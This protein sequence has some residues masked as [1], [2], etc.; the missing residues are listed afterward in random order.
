MLSKLYTSDK[1]ANNADAILN[2]ATTG[3][4]F[5]LQHART[6]D[7][8]R[9]YFSLTEDGR[10]LGIQR[11][12]FSECFFV[13]AMYEYGKATGDIKYT[14]AG[15]DMF[16]YVL[17]YH[18]KPELLGRPQLSGDAKLLPLNMPMIILNVIDEIGM[19]EKYQDRVNR[20]IHEILLHVQP[21]M[22]VVVENV[23]P[24]GTVLMARSDGRLCNPGHAIECAW[25]LLHHIRMVGCTGEFKHR[26][27]ELNNVAINMLDWS[28]DKGWD[29]QHDGILYFTDLA[30]YDASPLE[31]GMKLWWPHCETLIAMLMAFEHTSKPQYLSKFIQTIDY[32]KKTF[33]ATPSGGWYGYFDQ[34]GSRTHNYIGAAY[35]GFFHVPRALFVC[36]TILERLLHQS[37]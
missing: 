21:D 36:G 33:S 19:H 22:Q 15:L 35:K 6:E 3:A 32:I 26:E 10:P 27:Q 30:G 14:Q 4:T 16:E 8:K 17:L 1:K 9:C 2:A 34:G 23:L 37:E 20:C 7:G 13:M 18:D 28:F 11:K 31:S 25:F 5:L 24:D 29:M 12:I